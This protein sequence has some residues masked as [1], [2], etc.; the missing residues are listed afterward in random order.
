MIAR[1]RDGLHQKARAP[2]TGRASRREIA[3]LARLARPICSPDV[4]SPDLLGPPAPRPDH[5]ASRVFHTRSRPRLHHHG[6]PPQPAC[7][8][9]AHPRPERPHRPARR[10]GRVGSRGTD[11]RFRRERCS[12]APSPQRRRRR[13]AGGS[14]GSSGRSGS[15]PRRQ[16]RARWHWR[17]RWGWSAS[18]IRCVG[19]R[20]GSGIGTA[21]AASGSVRRSGQSP[22]SSAAR[23]SA[24]RGDRALGD[25]EGPARPDGMGL[26]RRRIGAL[27]APSELL[28]RARHGRVGGEEAGGT[29]PRRARRG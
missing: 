24:G 19:R 7:S 11:E 10:R 5:P 26:D 4:C 28:D 2:I 1:R 18:R 16:R 12:A 6:P 22:S 21:L 17:G 20:W 3:P 8:V 23:D 25:R 13:D 27:L 9:R 29:A 14:T 15:R